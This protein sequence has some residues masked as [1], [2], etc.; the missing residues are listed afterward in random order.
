MLETKAEYRYLTLIGADAV[1]MSTV[2]EIIAA[3][4][5]DLPCF[6]VSVI[7]DMC[8]PGKIK[9]VVIADILA[10][11]AKAEPKLTLLIKELIKLQGPPIIKEW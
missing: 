5:M 11:A 1:G 6:A 2:P 4:H 3:R 7:T 8:V 10:A 9:K